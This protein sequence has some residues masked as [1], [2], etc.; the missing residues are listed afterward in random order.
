MKC[1]DVGVSNVD[2]FSD[3]LIKAIDS[4]RSECG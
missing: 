2:Y 3:Q 1:V 4:A